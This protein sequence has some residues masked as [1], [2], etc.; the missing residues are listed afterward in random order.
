[1]LL[2]KQQHEALGNHV[3]ALTKEKKENVLTNLELVNLNN[4]SLLEFEELKKKT[5]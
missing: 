5:T 2:H 4:A 1:L 3:K